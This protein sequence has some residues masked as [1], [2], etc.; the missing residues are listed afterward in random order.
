MFLDQKKLISILMPVKNAELFLETCIQSILNQSFTKWELIAVDDSSSDNSYN[1]LQEYAENVSNVKVFSSTGSGIIDALKRAYEESS[2]DYIHR[3][4]ADDVMPLNKLELLK[5]ECNK[6]VVATGKVA[7]FTEEGSIGEGFTKYQQWIN[8]LMDANNLWKD[9]YLEC[10]LPSPAWM[11]RRDDFEQIGGF[12]SELLPEDYDLMFRI[13]ESKLQVN[14]VKD[15]VH[16][17]RDSSIRTSR[18][19]PT[20]F[21]MAYYPLKI[22]YF[23]KIDRNKA[24]PLIL[25]GAGKKG[26]AIA[27]LLKERNET[28]T[29]ITDNAKKI[30]LSIYEHEMVDRKDVNLQ[31]YQIILAI[32]SPLDK[33]EVT[34][35]LISQKCENFFWFC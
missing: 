32:S 31:D 21:P 30:G 25:W 28:F 27:K 19:N 15:V 9:P 12:Q 23:L 5:A 1:I 13:Y 18:N 2:G 17:W 11:M 7:Y 33:Q 34:Q 10:S 6:G 35:Q 26:K 29:W 20:Y 24:I 14:T 3:M 22:H 16:L 8:D 4:D